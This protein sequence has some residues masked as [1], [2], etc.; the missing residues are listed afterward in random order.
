MTLERLKKKIRFITKC[1]GYFD[2]NILLDKLDQDND[3]AFIFKASFFV[4][5]F[6]KNKMI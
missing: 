6:M 4:W 5:L 1:R 2:K 3:Y